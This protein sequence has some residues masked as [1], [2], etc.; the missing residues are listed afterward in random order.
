MTGLSYGDKSLKRPGIITMLNMTE[1]DGRYHPFVSR[2]NEFIASM[3]INE[4]KTSE[5]SDFSGK[6]HVYE[7]KKITCMY[8]ES[9]YGNDQYMLCVRDNIWS[10]VPESVDENLVFFN[11]W[12]FV[13]HVKDGLLSQMILQH[14]PGDW[15]SILDGYKDTAQIYW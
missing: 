9:Y 15:V 6:K 10:H 5:G 12:N 4:G 13:Y 1:V 11:G 2:L 8:Q 14:I 3:A 7:D